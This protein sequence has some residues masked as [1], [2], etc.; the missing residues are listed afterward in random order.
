M[1]TG[2]DDSLVSKLNT[3][4]LNKFV[5]NYENVSDDNVRAA[6]GYLE[7]ALGV[8]VE[9][10]L[11]TSKL[12]IGLI[13]GSIALIAEAFHSLSDILSSLIVIIGF[14]VAKQPPDPEHPYGHGRFEAIATLIVAIILV[15]IGFGIAS[16]SIDRLINP[17]SVSVSSSA[18][19]ILVITIIFKEL[20]ARVA[21]DL[22]RRIEARVLVADSLNQRVDSLAAVIVIIGLV[23]V[24][25]GFNRLDAVAG[26][27]V[28]GFIFYTAY[29]IAWD[30]T[31]F[32]LGQAPSEDMV[33]LIRHIARS[34]EGV[35]SPHSVYVH[36][37]GVRKVITLHILV[38]KDLSVERSHDIAS[39][40]ERRIGNSI[41]GAMVDVHVGPAYK[42]KR[43][44]ME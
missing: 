30:S 13:I 11:F 7:G 35:K 41:T 39:E 21:I 18:I 17:I 5:P 6:Y 28:V 22:G 23:G 14:R 34:V 9:T 33:E 1:R 8:I 38:D 43:G 19:G 25:L 24:A 42:L 4:L 29:D 27:A 2:R 15:A 32:L 16:R 20:L 3:F 36:D 10:L 40:V 12:I 37:Y 31:N 44:E 26:L